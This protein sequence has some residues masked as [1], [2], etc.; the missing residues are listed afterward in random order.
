MDE[1]SGA[2]DRLGLDRAR[3]S[4]RDVEDVAV[5]EACRTAVDHLFAR[6]PGVPRGRPAGAVRVGSTEDGEGL[7]HLEVALARPHPVEHDLGVPGVVGRRRVVLEL[8]GD[9]HRDLACLT[10]VLVVADENGRAPPAPVRRHAVEDARHDVPV[11]HRLALT[12]DDR[13][14]ELLRQP[15]IPLVDERAIPWRARRSRSVGDL[16]AESAERPERRKA[17]AGGQ[18]AAKERP[19]VERVHAEV[20]PLCRDG[21]C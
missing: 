10:P 9:D 11:A 2:E 7:E 14:V 13:V 18:T 16:G 1:P 3:G 5:L 12:L 17:A 4:G 8:L 19:P 21:A 20:P 15:Q 6:D